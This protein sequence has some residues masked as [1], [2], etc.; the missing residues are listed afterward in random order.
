MGTLPYLQNGK[1]FEGKKTTLINMREQPVFIEPN[2]RQIFSRV[3]GLFVSDQK[4]PSI[5]NVSYTGLGNPHESE[6]AGFF[7]N[8]APLAANLFGY[9]TIYYTPAAQ[10]VERIEFVRGAAGLMHGPQIGP[11]LNL[12]TRRADAEA[13]SSFRT[14][15]TT[16]SDGPYSTYNELKWSYNDVAFWR[17]LTTAVPTV[18]AAMRTTRSNKDMPVFPT[19][20][21]TT[22]AWGSI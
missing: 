11:V 7:Q 15:Q 17:R 10:R 1:I 18:R 16:G 9:P 14:D 21:S 2:L 8:N 19:R 4:I 3:P 20:G 6:F 5:Y 13:E 12:M 22:F